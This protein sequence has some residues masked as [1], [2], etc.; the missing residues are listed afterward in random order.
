MWEKGRWRKKQASMRGSEDR[1]TKNEQHSLQEVEGRG[2]SGDV[3]MEDGGGGNQFWWYDSG[4]KRDVREKSKWSEMK[5]SKQGNSL[6][7]G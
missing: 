6:R 2:F 4:A 7:L 1:K 5:V 3:A